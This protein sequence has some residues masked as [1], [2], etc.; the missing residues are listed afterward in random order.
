VVLILV[1]PFSTSRLY[2]QINRL[3][4]EILKTCAKRLQLRL[5]LALVLPSGFVALFEQLV[6]SG[7]FPKLVVLRLIICSTEKAYPLYYAEVLSIPC[8][9]IL[10]L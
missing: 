8:E 1:F 6:S 4:I 2:A 3:R 5:S 10:R 7:A 9:L